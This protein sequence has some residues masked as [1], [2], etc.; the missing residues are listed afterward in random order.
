MKVDTTR[1]GTQE[2]D[3]ETVL[4]FPRGIPGFEHCH[5]FHLFHEDHEHPVV[6]YL[7]ALEDPD[8]TL[9]VVDPGQ[10]GLSY[11]IPLTDTDVENLAFAA[12]D[13]VGVL[14]ILSTREDADSQRREPGSRITPHVTSPLLINARSRRGLQKHIT[15]LEYSIHLRVP[16]V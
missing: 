7:Q 9:S 2:V 6:Y 16:E 1:F 14:L 15:G 4:Q 13:S 8:V 10:L 3:P 11:E 5:R 12:N